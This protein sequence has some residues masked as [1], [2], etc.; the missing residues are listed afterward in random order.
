MISKF[1][2]RLFRPR[3]L[4][5][6]AHRL[7]ADAVLQARQPFLYAN[8]GVADTVDGRFDMIA[9]HL[10]LLSDALRSAELVHA[11]LLRQILIDRMVIDM[12]QSLREMGVGDV[13]IGKKIQKMAYALNGRMERYDE[14]VGDAQKMTQALLRNVY[15]SDE[16]MQKQAGKLSDYVHHMQDALRALPQAAWQNDLSVWPASEGQV[17]AA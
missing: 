12:D 7:Y 10:F 9:L 17:N 16:A 4:E 11:Q 6:R 5:H 15:R 8:L 14:A 2:R 1:F 13:S 3:E